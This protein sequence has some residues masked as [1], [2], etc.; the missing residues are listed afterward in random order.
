[1]LERLK[2]IIQKIIPFL[3]IIGGI[4]LLLYPWISNY[5][6][7]NRTDGIIETYEKQI[8]NIE[9]D[10]KEH[11]LLVAKAYN[12]AIYETPVSLTDPFIRNQVDEKVGTDYENILK[13]NDTGMMGTI[14]IPKIAV[15]LPIYH[16]SDDEVLEKGI[17]HLQGTS[18]PIGGENTH[19]VLTGHTGL[20]YAKMFTDLTELEENDYFFITILDDKM[21]YK[22]K[23]I[24]VV[25]PNEVDDLSIQSGKD[26]VTLMTCTP[27]G[28]ND[29]RLLVTGERTE[30]TKMVYQEET[31]KETL[32]TMWMRSYTKAIL[33]GLASTPFIIFLMILC[34]KKVNNYRR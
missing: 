17:G 15:S 22:V 21:A 12:Q 4:S 30:Y 27:Y 7:D 3:I 19:S 33:I 26:F 13:I 25:L 34:R 9:Q 20:R 18:F 5:L 31:Q 2:T 16:G 6:F 32:D 24:K 10:E 29:H 11:T 23:K 8:N 28:I 1:M 14:E